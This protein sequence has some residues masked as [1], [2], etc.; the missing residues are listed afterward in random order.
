LAHATS[1][2]EAVEERTGKQLKQSV[3]AVESFRPTFSAFS[4][5]SVMSRLCVVMFFAK[6]TLSRV[7]TDAKKVN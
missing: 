2:S 1:S 7:G 6:K 4:V 5:H 3:E